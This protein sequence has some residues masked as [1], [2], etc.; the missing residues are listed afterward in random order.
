MKKSII[1]LLIAS[2]AFCHDR[3]GSADWSPFEWTMAA[4]L[5]GQSPVVSVTD[6]GIGAKTLF[7]AESGTSTTTNYYRDGVPLGFGHQWLDSPW[8]ISLA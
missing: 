5:S 7:L 2:S 3:D 4:T 1:F 8:H 6:G